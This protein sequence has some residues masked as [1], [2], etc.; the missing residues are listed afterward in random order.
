[1][2]SMAKIGGGITVIRKSERN[3]SYSKSNTN[4][5]YNS[6]RT[7]IPYASFKRMVE[8]FSISSIKINKR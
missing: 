1:M 5:R 8:Y 6:V 4:W 2:E 7:G 3:I